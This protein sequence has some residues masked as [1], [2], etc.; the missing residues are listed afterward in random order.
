MNFLENFSVKCRFVFGVRNTDFLVWCVVCVNGLFDGINMGN[1]VAD[2]DGNGFG[3]GI[4]GGDGELYHAGA[5]VDG[6]RLVENEVADAVVDGVAFEVLDGL[7]G[8]GVVAY[9]DVGSGTH[10][11]VGLHALLGQRRERMLGSPMQ[12]DYDIGI[13]LLAAQQA[14]A[15]C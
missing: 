6:P 11:L 10:K 7:Q 1:T 14:D 13:W 9:D 15:P 4:G 12:A 2:G 5:C 3:V 8:V